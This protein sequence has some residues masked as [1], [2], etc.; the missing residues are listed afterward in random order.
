[1]RIGIVRG[2]RRGRNW[3]RFLICVRLVDRLLFG[4]R[5]PVLVRS[6]V[7]IVACVLMRRVA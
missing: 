7:R 2:V 4:K 1:V 6:V 3:I 5:G